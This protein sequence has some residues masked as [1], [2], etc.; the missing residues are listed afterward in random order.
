ML[1]LGTGIGSAIFVDG[2]LLP[3]TEFGHLPIRGVDAEDRASDR[4]RKEEDLSWKKWSKA[5]ERVSG[6]HGVFLLA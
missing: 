2:H 5:S 6:C 1:T 4:I 3:N